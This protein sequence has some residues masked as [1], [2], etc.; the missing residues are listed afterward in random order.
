MDRV[1]R[2]GSIKSSTASKLLGMKLTGVNTSQLVDVSFPQMVIHWIETWFH[3]HTSH[4]AP[5]K[6]MEWHSS[7]RGLHA[8]LACHFLIIIISIIIVWHIFC[9]FSFCSH[10]F[11][12]CSLGCP[13]LVFL[14]IFQSIIF[15]L[16]NW[17]ER[18]VEKL[19]LECFFQFS[20]WYPPV[21]INSFWT[22]NPSN[23]PCV[24]RFWSFWSS[25][26]AVSSPS[27]NSTMPYGYHDLYIL[28]IRS[29][30]QMLQV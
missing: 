27:L 14:T 28:K 4:L 11:I 18:I 8:T 9:H 1:F 6:L 5:S 3:Q 12:V 17:S 22:W 26:K 23:V 30:R 13:F 2:R 16:L 15:L 29:L 7:V 24:S 20:F 21:I 10:T 19:W 25:S